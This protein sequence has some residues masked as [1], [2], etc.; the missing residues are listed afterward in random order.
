MR[1][2]M[3][4]AAAALAA[5]LSALI[6]AFPAAAGTWNHDGT[7]WRYED[8][9]GRSVE[10]GWIKDR[11]AWY[12]FAKDGSGKGA[13]QVGWINEDGK[14]YYLDPQTGAMVTNTVIDGYYV[15]ESGVWEEAGGRSSGS[16]T[17]SRRSS[18]ADDE[19]YEETDTESEEWLDEDQ[20]D[21]DDSGANSGPG[22]DMQDLTRDNGK[23]PG[24]KAS[25]SSKTVYTTSGNVV[26]RSSYT[27]S[28]LTPSSYNQKHLGDV[29]KSYDDDDDEDYDEEEGYDDDESGGTKA[30]WIAAN[31]NGYRKEDEK[32]KS[33]Y[34]HNGSNFDYSQSTVKDESGDTRTIIKK[35]RVRGDKADSDS[36]DDED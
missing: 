28:S 3:K 5:G 12:F 31:G 18:S 17:T 20:E 34:S 21:W 16:K 1:R 32:P 33:Q 2:Q 30:D 6:T 35:T 29:G 23:G 13:M 22:Y 27:Q 15:D 26:E 8:D 14:W 10:A 7:S 4:Y 36:D 9:A 25:S 24:G 19:D 11:N